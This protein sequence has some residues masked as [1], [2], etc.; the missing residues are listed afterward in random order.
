MRCIGVL[1][2]ILLNWCSSIASSNTA[3]KNVV[4]L[5]VF[6]ST[7]IYRHD[8]LHVC[9]DKKQFVAVERVNKKIVI[10]SEVHG[11]EI[12][13]MP[14]NNKTEVV[15]LGHQTGEV[16]TEGWNVFP[17]SLL[18]PVEIRLPSNHTCDECANGFYS[19]EKLHKPFECLECPSVLT[20]EEFCKQ[21]QNTDTMCDSTDNGARKSLFYYNC[22]VN[23]TA[24][25][26]Y[27]S[28]EAQGPTAFVI[29]NTNVLPVGKA[30]CKRYKTCDEGRYRGFEFDD[31]PCM[32]CSDSGEYGMHGLTKKEGNGSMHDI[33]NWHQ[34]ATCVCDQGRYFDEKYKRCTLCPPGKYQDEMGLS[35]TCKDCSSC[36]S[37]YFY[38]SKDCSGCK[39]DEY[40]SQTQKMCRPCPYTFDAMKLSGDFH[41]DQ[42]S[43]RYYINMGLCSN[44]S[45]S[46][47]CQTPSTIIS[48][49]KPCNAGQS[50]PLKYDFA[51][52]SCESCSRGTF[53][54]SGNECRPWKNCSMQFFM[55]LEGNLTHDR[56]CVKEP[57]TDA[58]WRHP[59]QAGG[60]ITLE[61]LDG[62]F[63]LP[64]LN[65]DAPRL[66]LRSKTTTIIRWPDGHPVKILNNSM[67]LPEKSPVFEIIH[68]KR[69][70]MVNLS[71]GQKIGQLSYGCEQ[72]STMKKGEI[73]ILP[74]HSIEDEWKYPSKPVKK[75]RLEVRNG[76]FFA[77]GVPT[78]T[79]TLFF[80]RN[81]SVIIS[82]PLQHSV[83]IMTNKSRSSKNTSL[84]T[85]IE[86]KRQTIVD[87]PLDLKEQQLF[88]SCEQY[89]SIEAGRIKILPA[90]SDLDPEVS[91]FSSH[92]T[93]NLSSL[94]KVECEHPDIH[95]SNTSAYY[96][97]IMG[98]LWMTDE[99]SLPFHVGQPCRFQCKPGAF[100]NNN[101]CHPCQV[102]KFSVRSDASSCTSCSPGHYQNKTGQ[103]H[104]VECE[105]GKF[106][107]KFAATECLSFYSFSDERN[108]PNQSH[109]VVDAL[110]DVNFPQNTSNCIKCPVNGFADKVRRNFGVQHCFE[111]MCANA[112]EIENI[113][114]CEN[115]TSP[116]KKCRSGEF[117]RKPDNQC[118][119][120]TAVL[121]PFARLKMGTTVQEER[122]CYVHSTCAKGFAKLTT[123]SQVKSLQSVLQLFEQPKSDAICVKLKQTCEGGTESLRCVE[124]RNN[125]LETF[126]PQDA[127]ADHIIETT[128]EYSILQKSIDEDLFSNCTHQ[129]G[130]SLRRRLLQAQPQFCPDDFYF[131]LNTSDCMSCPDNTVVS[132]QINAATSQEECECRAGYYRNSHINNGEYECIECNDGAQPE[133]SFYC[134]GGSRKSKCNG[135]AD[136]EAATGRCECPQNSSSKLTKTAKQLLDCIPNVQYEFGD[137]MKI[138]L[139]PNRG[140]DELMQYFPKG[141]FDVAGNYLITRDCYF[142]CKADMHAVLNAS[143][144]CVCDEENHWEWHEASQQCECKEKFHEESGRCKECPQ[145]F[146]CAGKGSPKEACSASMISPAGS[147]SQ[148]ACRCEVGKY[149]FERSGTT[150]CKDCERHHYCPNGKQSIPCNNEGNLFICTQ[151]KLEF[152]ALC[153]PGWRL[154]CATRCEEKDCTETFPTQIDSE[155]TSLRDYEININDRRISGSSEGDDTFYVNFNIKPTDIKGLRYSMEGSNIDSLANFKK[156]GVLVS[157]LQMW[158]ANNSIIVLNTNHSLR[159]DKD[160]FKCLSKQDLSNILV[161]TASFIPRTLRIPQDYSSIPLLKLRIQTFNLLHNPEFHLTWGLFLSCPSSMHAADELSEHEACLP[162]CESQRLQLNLQQRHEIEGE[163]FFLDVF[164]M[165]TPTQYRYMKKT[166]QGIL[167]AQSKDVG[168]KNSE[169]FLFD[170]ETGKR[171]PAI[172]LSERPIHS[173]GRILFTLHMPTWH[174]FSFFP[175]I[176]LGVCNDEGQYILRSIGD[177]NTETQDHVVELQ[178]LPDV[179][180][181]TTNTKIFAFLHHNI[182]FN[183]YFEK[184]QD[185][186]KI[187]YSHI[188]ISHEGRQSFSD[189]ISSQE[190]FD[191]LKDVAWHTKCSVMQNENTNVRFCG[192]HAFMIFEEK[193]GLNSALFF[194]RVKRKQ[195]M[196]MKKILEPSDIDSKCTNCLSYTGQPYAMKKIVVLSPFTANTDD[197]TTIENFE[198]ADVDFLSPL[199]CLEIAVLLQVHNNSHHHMLKDI[200]IGTYCDKEAKLSLRP[201]QPV[202]IDGNILHAYYFFAPAGVHETFKN[203]LAVSGR[204]ILV[205]EEETQKRVFLYSFNIS[206]FTC[207]QHLVASMDSKSGQCVCPSG[208]APVAMPCHDFNGCQAIASHSGYIDATVN[209]NN[210]ILLSR[211]EFTEE[212]KES[213]YVK[214]CLPCTGDFYCV[215]GSVA[216][217]RTCPPNRHALKMLAENYDDCLCDNQTKAVGGDRFHSQCEKCSDQEICNADVAMSSL[218]SLSCRRN[219][220]VQTGVISTHRKNYTCECDS[221]YYSAEGT[222]FQLRRR[223]IAKIYKGKY[224]QYPFNLST[225]QRETI[226]QSVQHI[227]SIC[228]AGSYC[229]QGVRTKCPNLSKSPVGSSFLEN[230]TCEMGSVLRLQQH[231]C[232]KCVRNSSYVCIDNEEIT[233]EQGEIAHPACPCATPGEYR[234]FIA[235]NHTK[236]LPCPKNHFCPILHLDP[237]QQ[238]IPQ[239]CPDNSVSFKNS[240]VMQNC[241]CKPGFYAQLT[242]SHKMTCI[243]CEENHYCDGIVQRPCALSHTSEAGSSLQQH[244]TKSIPTE[245]TA[246]VPD[247]SSCRAG[248]VPRNNIPSSYWSG[249]HFA[250]HPLSS[251]YAMTRLQY[252][253]YL[254]TAENTP[255]SCVLCPPSFA[256]NNDTIHLC[257]KIGHYMAV[258]MGAEKCT[259]ALLPCPHGVHRVQHSSVV[260]VGVSSCF[261]DASLW[262]SPNRPDFFLFLKKTASA[263]LMM[264]EQNDFNTSN[265]WK[266]LVNS[267]NKEL[268]HEM[269]HTYSGQEVFAWSQNAASAGIAT[270]NVPD[271]WFQFYRKVSS[272]HRR[273]RLFSKLKELDSGTGVAFQTLL[274]T[275]WALALQEKNLAVEPV[276]VLQAVV[277]TALTRSIAYAAKNAIAYEWNRCQPS[278]TKPPLVV[279]FTIT[280]HDITGF[281]SYF[282]KSLQHSVVYS[283]PPSCVGATDCNVDN[284]EYLFSSFATQSQVI[285]ID[286]D[287]MDMSRRE[288]TIQDKLLLRGLFSAGTGPCITGTVRTDIIARTDVN[289]CKVCHAKDYEKTFYNYGTCSPCHVLHEDECSVLSASSQK[290]SC[291]FTRDAMCYSLEGMTS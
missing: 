248:F 51:S 168:G 189:S 241:S 107:H 253:A 143:G 219:S 289:R 72:H 274:P 125:N 103:K 227:C 42:D 120:C 268:F 215:D 170:I 190:N 267:R 226:W 283:A 193:N 110:N 60:E 290:F 214:Y 156:Q 66:F 285:Q 200:V 204:L 36:H 3:Y 31:H 257:T 68:M 109:Y 33:R 32:E 256:C 48:P 198:N 97:D 99:L 91:L 26:M 159:V 286:D 243:L 151:M 114:R 154:D 140:K 130:S 105:M 98:R 128:C 27:E 220:V 280:S 43:E 223:E 207:G 278:F 195:K 273:D 132:N 205:T 270:I 28:C 266:A 157:Q 216:G 29:G 121:P 83:Q 231:T 116:E 85:I 233:C 22:G 52:N 149:S 251:D 25:K 15:Q 178:N 88:Y 73:T 249:A 264:F 271:T 234:V 279:L 199:P 259:M 7:T 250:D 101:Q 169:F 209:S 288:Q 237:V 244:C 82:W 137:D 218:R 67:D 144:F 221:G 148:E 161:S 217:V 2:V 71:T 166:S 225:Q 182:V 203:L 175:V 191:H 63:R 167:L 142:Q 13:F 24:N 254:S 5:K 160:T 49:R 265:V 281:L 117:L 282:S 240:F 59:E 46:D 87:V 89:P 8:T 122:D 96:E 184:R 54:E 213:L 131:N 50:S 78:A 197:M 93:V 258:G 70:T 95:S 6:S 127:N 147:K 10:T 57:I 133:K 126:E 102:G 275:I 138:Q 247:K 232:E 153:E 30:A 56:V 235:P 284:S 55:T 187:F 79:P 173:G 100:R 23:K 224:S 139:C 145:N 19:P 260:N 177:E 196:E 141:I 172:S 164:P 16:N 86:N 202:A 239:P 64:G 269:S 261:S 119:H 238:N 14:T 37:Q 287:H 53:S 47:Q 155:K 58:I 136:Q 118:V 76:H 152:G 210:H 181:K 206:C 174:F 134:T 113:W 1:L 112:T 90:D 61:V 183:M 40:W 186:F 4:Q 62:Q 39:D 17:G 179:C 236:C 255:A 92:R 201:V 111:T 146:F 208:Y 212:M 80:R 34:N 211:E 158:C 74:A 180:Q 106:S 135:D 188:D 104:C 228:P 69:E 123:R 229:R 185:G 75:I 84:Y 276:V 291:S 108:C 277:R 163:S 81:S 222:S 262:E 18:V 124:G 11:L 21:E 77:A 12:W 41:A 246:D 192:I 45:F 35:L 252:D 94:P 171:G 162:G 165:D 20:V 245:C 230:C 65:D 176:L 150:I 263:A 194:F 9:T 242:D 44:K 129:G 272:R 115:E 38:G